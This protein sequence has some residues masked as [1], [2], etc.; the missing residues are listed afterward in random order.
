MGCMETTREQRQAALLEFLKAGS[1]ATQR[2]LLKLLRGRGIRAD[3]S[4]LSRDLVELGVT[5]Q[6]GRYALPEKTAPRPTEPRFD[7]AVQSFTTCGPHLIVIRTALG[8]A[9][10]LAVQIDR[11]AEPSITA[12]LAGDD[13]IFVAT[14][15]R[16]S[17]V[18]A[19]RR[20]EEWFGDKHET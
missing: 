17:Q 20:L 16:R 1:A 2:E 8:A 7:A 11:R 18:V 6:R 12:T 19:L 14:K 10:P 3:Q 4:T 13:A 9:Q 15:S 5:K